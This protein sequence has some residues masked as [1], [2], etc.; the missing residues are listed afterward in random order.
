MRNIEW[1]IFIFIV[2]LLIITYR[3]VRSDDEM[4]HEFMNDIERCT[5]C[6]TETP[7]DNAD[8]R[9]LRFVDDII[10][11]CHKCHSED[12]LGRSHPVDVEPPFDMDV[13]DDL[14]LDTYL[15]VN[16]ATCHDPHKKKYSNIK[17]SGSKFLINSRTTEGY[18]TYFLRRSNI[19]SALCLA[20]HTKI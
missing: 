7:E 14:H 18:K 8:Y 15:H 6:H 20:C 3:S 1:I 5:E 11:I 17:Y 12:F 4:G 13:P 2:I 10:N 19:K 9:D 16:C